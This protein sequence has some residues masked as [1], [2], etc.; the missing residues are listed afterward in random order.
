MSNTGYE[1]L[2]TFFEDVA[3]PQEIERHLDQ[4]LYCLVYYEHKEGTQNFFEIYKDIFEFKT[5]LQTIK[6]N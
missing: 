5:V 4:L 1:T 2:E 6:N 3:S